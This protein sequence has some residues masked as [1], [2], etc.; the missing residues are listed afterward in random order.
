MVRRMEAKGVEPNEA[1]LGRF[2]AGR[3]CMSMAFLVFCFVQSA[4]ELLC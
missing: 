1:T 2:A 4:P 3:R